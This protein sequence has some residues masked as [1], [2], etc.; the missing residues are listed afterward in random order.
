VLTQPK[1]FD[2]QRKV[3]ESNE[4]DVELLKS[5]E[6]PSYNIGS[7]IAYEVTHFGSRQ[8]PAKAGFCFSET[9]ILQANPVQNLTVK[10]QKVI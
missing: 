6:Y 2:D 3:D 10:I 4:H 5:T 8:E 7:G 9:G 1:R